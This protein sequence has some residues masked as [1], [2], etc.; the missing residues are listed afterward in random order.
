MTDR[1][2]GAWRVTE[3][4]YSPAGELL[5]RVHQDRQLHEQSDGSLRVYQL[6]S[7]TASL[8]NHPMGEFRGE[9]VFNLTREGNIRRY[10]GP[11]VLGFATQWS[12]GMI[13][14]RGIWPHFGYNFTSFSATISPTRQLTGGTFSRAGEPIAVI[15]GLGVMAVPDVPAAYP[16]LRG[17]DVTPNQSVLTREDSEMHA[18]THCYGVREDTVGVV[19]T[20]PFEQIDIADIESGMLLHIL[21]TYTTE[22]ERV[23]FDLLPLSTSLDTAGDFIGLTDG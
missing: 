7:P 2:L 13:T 12:P 19:G 11:D 21:K 23:R 3:Y 5:G 1:F 14:G 16:I 4:V 15:V 20:T 6:C 18:L 10:N 9:W 17:I 22:G 8:D